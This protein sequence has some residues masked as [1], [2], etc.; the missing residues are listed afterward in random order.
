MGAASI[1]VKQFASIIAAMAFIDSVMVGRYSVLYEMVS[2]VM[3]VVA[4]KYSCKIFE[5]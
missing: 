5:C 1:N 3:L 2:V 4:L